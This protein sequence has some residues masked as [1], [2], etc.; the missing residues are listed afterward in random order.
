MSAPQNVI[1]VVFDFDDTLTDDSTTKLL[2]S[3][4]INTRD[5]WQTKM[6]NLTDDGWDPPLA[7]MKLMLDNVGEGKPLGKL[8]NRDLSEFGRTLDFYPG[9]PQLFDD[10]QNLVRPHEISKPTVEFYIISGGLE[11]VIKGCKI[12]PY[13]RGIWGSRFH[14]E[15]GQIC[16]IKNSL[17]FTEKTKY[18]FAINKGVQDRIRDTPYVVNRKID[19]LDRRIPI[20]NMIYIGDG[21]TDVPCFSLMKLFRGTAF[22][23][24][25]PR[26]TGSAKKA[27]EQLVAPERVVS[28]HSPRYREDDD[29]GSL[30]RMAITEICLRMERKTGSPLG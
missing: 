22:G 2:E 5:F 27:W 14:E 16:Y 19:P 24:F 23:V 4:G 12:A 25:D 20:E 6:K 11:E 7:Y 8:T 3:R 9:L 13:F 26:K 28:T 30:L 29:L 18:L 10:L 17:S 15:D 1:A 21:I